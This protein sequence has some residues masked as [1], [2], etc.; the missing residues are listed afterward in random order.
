M[1]IDRPAYNL[2]LSPSARGNLPFLL[3]RQPDERDVA[4]RIDAGT[5]ASY[6]AVGQ[7]TA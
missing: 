3:R 1:A 7:P 4:D 2:S 5:T 6:I